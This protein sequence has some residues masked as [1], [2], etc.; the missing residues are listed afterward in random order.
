MGEAFLVL[1]D[2][3]RKRVYDECGIKALRQSESYAGDSIFDCDAF[4]VFD[5]FY[6]GDDPLGRDFLLANCCDFD[7]GFEEDGPTAFSRDENHDLS[8]I[9]LLLD[10]QSSFALLSAESKRCGQLLAPSSEV[11]M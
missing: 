6:S 8:A 10:G 4:Q 2:K 3:H 1:R 11:D 5:S 7:D 9:D